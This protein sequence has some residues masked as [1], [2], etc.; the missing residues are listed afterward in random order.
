MIVRTILVTVL[1]ST[2]L[3]WTTLKG[4]QDCQIPPGTRFN[5]NRCNP[6]SRYVKISIR[7]T[8]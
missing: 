8:L 6:A 1:K 5:N 7:Y 4:E 3:F 2:Q